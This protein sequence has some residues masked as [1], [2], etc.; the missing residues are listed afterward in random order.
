MTRGIVFPEAL[1]EAYEAVEAWRVEKNGGEEIG[2]YFSGDFRQNFDYRLYPF[3][4]Q[5]VWLRLWHPDPDRSVLLVPDF[6]SYS[7][8]T[9]ASLPGIE[10][11]FVYGGWDPIHSG[12]SYALITY[13]THF[14]LGGQLNGIPYPDLYFNL[15][16]ERDFLGPLLEHVVLELAIAILLFFLLLL[17]SYE[18]NVQQQLGLTVF[19]LIVASG[20]L[21]FA[22]ILDL[23]SI[24]GAVESQ[25]LTYLEWFP[26]I[27]VVF[28][29]LVVLERRA[30]GAA[31]ASP[32]HGLHWRSGTGPGV[33]ARIVGDPARGHPQGLLLLTP[34]LRPMPQATCYLVLATPR[35][36]ST[37]LGQGLQASGLAGD[38]RGVLRPQDVVL[39]GA[40][41]HADPA[42]LRR[43]ADAVAVDAER[44]LR[45]QAALRATLPI[46]E[47][48]AAG[49]GAG[50]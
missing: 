8:T 35:S 48:G 19:D 21:L 7:D 10:K 22:V 40:V 2:W 32:N 37:L 43:A 12:F 14:G 42:G 20:G 25:E 17:T 45:R 1:E 47:P 29:V 18:S 33:L 36:G 38:P 27:L 26:L 49:S 6:A 4:R 30:A 13:N 15:S 28:I 39:D 5:A 41:E 9:P 31:M 23:N 44:R 24:R 50:R 3:D 16:V 34:A 11:D 46:G